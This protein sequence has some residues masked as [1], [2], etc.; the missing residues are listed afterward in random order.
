VDN[1]ENHGWTFGFAFGGAIATLLL[2]VPRDCV[3]Q[4]LGGPVPVEWNAIDEATGNIECT[5]YVGLPT[6]QL[7]QLE[8]FIA[9]VIVG[10]VLG[11]LWELH[12]LLQRSGG[13]DR[14]RLG[15]T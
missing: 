7:D 11:G 3:K 1:A 2:T 14:H 12:L 9:A 13:R 6:Y 15:P 4:G 5:S 10:I 8:A